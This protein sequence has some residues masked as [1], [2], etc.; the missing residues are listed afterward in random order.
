MWP[1][2][3]GISALITSAR[4]WKAVCTWSASVSLA[5]CPG[6][7]SLSCV[8]AN[9]QRNPE[10]IDVRID[11]SVTW[12]ADHLLRT[13]LRHKKKKKIGWKKIWGE[14]FFEHPG[15]HET[16]RNA[17]KS[18]SR[19]I[20]LEVKKI[21]WMK[22]NFAMDVQTTDDIAEWLVESRLASIRGGSRILVKGQWG[23]VELKI[24]FFFF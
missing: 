19:K 17:Q 13:W 2:G 20:F 12:T 7:A 9:P 10:E 15:W 24:G 18:E 23:G 6:H 16:S 3:G 11:W 1:W 5:E 22:K 21:S 14:N 8:I 4:V